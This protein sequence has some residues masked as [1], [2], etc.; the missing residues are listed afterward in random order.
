VYAAGAGPA[1]IA[2][3]GKGYPSGTRLGEGSFFG[4]RAGRHAAFAARSA[5]T[6]Q[7]E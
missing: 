7:H 3:D 5:V 6:A 2:Q 4:R 1:N